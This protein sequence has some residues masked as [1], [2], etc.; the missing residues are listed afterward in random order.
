MEPLSSRVAAPVELALPSDGNGI[1]W[2]AA[3]IEDAPAVAA[4]YQAMAAVDHPDWAETLDEVEDELSTS[5]ADLPHNTAVALDGSE[6]V[7]FGQVIPPP[8]PETIVRS[9]LFGGVRPD[10]RGRGIGRQLVEWQVARATQQLAASQ[11]A[12]PG[13]ILLYAEEANERAI[14]M[15]ESAGFR[16]TRYFAK[17]TRDLSEP[18]PEP[19]PLHG[20]RIAAMTPELSEPVRAAKN[21]AFRDHWG[22]QPTGREQWDAMLAQPSYRPDLS[23]VALDGAGAVAGFVIVDVVEEDFERQGFPG[24]YIMLVGTV[25]EFRQRGVAHALLAATMRASRAVGHE[26][27]VLDVD[28]DNPSGAFG[29]YTG[30]GFRPESRSRAL[31]IA[32]E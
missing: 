5:W 31:V 21:A 14:R 9:I 28:G 6:V 8:D 27:I 30:M 24:G 23:F 3:T 1:R 16:S 32:F 10:H 7:A 19:V 25:R 22:S 18:I 15:A 29:L 13:W 11:L 2:R 4:L 12:L 17:M 20:L 26:R